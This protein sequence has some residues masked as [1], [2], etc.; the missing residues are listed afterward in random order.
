MSWFSE[1]FDNVQWLKDNEE[2]LR[3]LLPVEPVQADEKLLL[4]IAFGVKLLGV[5]WTDFHRD[6][7]VIMTR[8]CAL[9][10]A[11]LATKGDLEDRP[12]IVSVRRNPNRVP[13]EMWEHGLAQ[14][15]QQHAQAK[16]KQRLEAQQNREAEIAARS[17]LSRLS[18]TRP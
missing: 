15:Q 17:L 10:I 1:T 13:A 6:L 14:Q 4:R 3:N 2:R 12:Q 18:K 8:L 9:G 5:I 16:E 7:P 11:Q